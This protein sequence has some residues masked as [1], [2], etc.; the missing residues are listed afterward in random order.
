MSIGLRR[1]RIIAITLAI[2]ATLFGKAQAADPPSD[3]EINRKLDPFITCINDADKRLLQTFEGYHKLLAAIQKNPNA[4]SFLFVGGFEH[5]D[6]RLMES[7]KCAEG[8]ERIIVAAPKMEDLDRLG[9]EYAMT[10]RAFA[11]LALQ[12]DTYYDMKDYKDDK[13]AKGIALDEKLAPLMA[14]L[15]ELSAG[16]HRGVRRQVAVLRERELAALEVKEGKGS[17]WQ[18]LNYVLVARRAL[19]AFRDGE[20]DGV[21]AAVERLQQA[22]DDGEAYANAHQDEAKGPGGLRGWFNL[23]NSAGVFLSVVKDMNRKLRPEAKSTPENLNGT[24]NLVVQRFNDLVQRY[25]NAG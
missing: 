1:F 23:R 24:F 21:I 8:L 18:A 10:I 7:V 20:Q 11:P 22:Y 13:G 4:Q 9:A 19:D 14:K 12:A 6:S 2:A 5:Y 25:N 17:H 16:I 15:E 3:D